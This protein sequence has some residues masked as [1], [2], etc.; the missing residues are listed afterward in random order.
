M[1]WTSGERDHT[2][3]YPARRSRETDVSRCEA[4]FK[5]S[6]DALAQTNTNNTE[7]AVDSQAWG[8]AKCVLER[9]ESSKKREATAVGSLKLRG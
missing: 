6:T 5:S 4:K 3:T 8:G 2:N 9:I 1:S 7:L